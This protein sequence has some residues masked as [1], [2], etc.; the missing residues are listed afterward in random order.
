VAGTAIQAQTVKIG[1]MA[2]IT[3][4]AASDGASVKN[5]IKLAVDA[6]N[7]SG[8]V[9]GQK[10]E[11]IVYDDAADPKQ[12]T[13]LARKLIEQDQ[14]K[15]FVAGSYSMP[16]R[17]V[18]P[19]FNDEKIPLVAAYA[20]HPD[21]TSGGKYTYCFRNGF[22]GA[23]E[24]R[25]GAYTCVTLLKGKKIV[26]LTSDNDAG[27]EMAVGF[28]QFMDTPAAKGAQVVSWGTY[29]MSEKDYKPYLAKIKDLNPDVV[30]SPGYYFQSGPMIKQAREMGL[31]AKFVGYEGADSP[32]FVDIAG[33]D[34]EGYSIT[35]N[36]N[37]DDK[38]PLV[39]AFLKEYKTQ[40]KV[41]PDMVGASAYDAF[42]IIVEGIKRA[43][44]VE[45]PA[46]QQAIFNLHDYNGLTG[47]IHGFEKGEV[48]KEVQIQVVKNGGFHYEGVVTDPKLIHP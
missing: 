35:T 40:F 32:E 45:G 47:M 12:A 25:A 16:S 15:A 11:A 14:V 48:V 44:S 43:K 17:A 6:V 13:A 29:P 19:L 33:K 46:I 30:Y 22:L 9:L 26:V 34:A 4:F 24:G 28:K 31:K 23:V 10:V 8:G 18:A 3:G 41:D 36:L 39:Q 42:M 20:V 1:V 37:R 2:P 5:S 27:K 38:R 7:A 21:V